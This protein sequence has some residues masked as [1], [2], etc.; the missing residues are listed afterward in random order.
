MLCI[1]DL[2]LDEYGRVYLRSAGLTGLLTRI[3]KRLDH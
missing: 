3:T 2:N 1:L